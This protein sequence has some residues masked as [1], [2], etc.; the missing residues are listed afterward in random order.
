[1]EV[2]DAVLY[3]GVR[4]PHGRTTPN[5]NTWSAHL[6]LHFVDR[7]GPHAGEAFDGRVR[8]EPVDFDFA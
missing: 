8:L 7:N 3:Y 4:Y 1:L 6:F 2:G 5:P